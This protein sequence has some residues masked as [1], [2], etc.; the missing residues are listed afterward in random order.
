MPSPSST[1]PTRSPGGTPSAV[2]AGDAE[3]LGE[4]RH[5]GFEIEGRRL[6]RRLRRWRRPNRMENASDPI[7]PVLPC[8]ATVPSVLKFSVPL[9]S[10]A[11]GERAAS[12]VRVADVRKLRPAKCWGRSSGS[13]RRS[14]AARPGCRTLRASFRSA[15]SPC[16]SPCRP[17]VGV[18]G[19]GVNAGLI[20]VQVGVDADIL[21]SV[22]PNR[23]RRRCSPLRSRRGRSGSSSRCHR[24]ATGQPCKN[25]PC[26]LTM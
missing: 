24:C 23:R 26:A 10:N 19:G 20:R 5:A 8:G 17:S 21:K 3:A 1:R 22:R 11:A 16:Q 7:V 18:R 25:K 13:R 9:A 2:T 14:C 12:D 4:L 15:A 6:D